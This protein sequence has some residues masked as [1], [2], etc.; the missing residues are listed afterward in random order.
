VVSVAAFTH[1]ACVAQ[2]APRGGSLIPALPPGL[3]LLPDTPSSGIMSEDALNTF[4]PG[5][6]HSAAD[7]VLFIVNGGGFSV[8]SKLTLTSNTTYRLAVGVGTR[9]SGNFGGLDFKVETLSGNQL[10]EWIG[11]NRNFVAPGGFADFSRSFTTGP[12]PPRDGEKLRITI[13]Q[14]KG[15]PVNAY[16]DVQNIRLTATRA[17]NPHFGGQPIDVLIVAGQ[18]NAHGWGSDASQLSV[19]NQRYAVSPNPL[20]LLA[21]KERNLPDPL[22][23]TG[24]F[25]TLSPQGPGFAGGFNGFGPE[26]AVGTDLADSSQKPV[27]II[28]YA[29]GSAGLNLNFKKSANLLYPTFTAFV[30]AAQQQLREQDFVPTLRAVFWLQGETDVALTPELYAKNVTDLVHDLRQDL[31]APNLEF[32][33]TEINANMPAWRSKSQAVAVVNQAMVDLGKQDPLVYFIPT[34][35][36]TNGFADA[37]HYSANQEISIGQRWAKAYRDHN[38]SA[39]SR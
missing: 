4:Y 32:F 15:A 8:A 20:A 28:K 13:S 6:R 5:L 18:S 11:A 24:T 7:P 26:L 31:H 34:A 16:T 29:I 3:Y 35:D 2:D 1:S 38:M 10:G 23:N 17:A 9:R 30:A 33:L 37:V 39:S 12:N 19:E 14:P 22:D 25:A 27:A 36:L 21:Y